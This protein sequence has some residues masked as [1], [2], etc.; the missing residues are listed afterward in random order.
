MSL[1][2][3]VM[4]PAAFVNQIAGGLRRALGLQLFNF[5]MI[6]DVR[7]GDRYLVID[8]NYFPGYAKMPGYETVL[9]DFFWEMVHKDDAAD[10]EKEEKGSNHAVVK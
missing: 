10:P 3:A 2:D 6:R 8:I 5:D 1:E 4:P 7:A 9:T